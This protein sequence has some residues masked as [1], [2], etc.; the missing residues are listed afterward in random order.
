MA[1]RGTTGAP[2]YG[3]KLPSGANT[4]FHFSQ[5]N[6]GYY[7]ITNILGPSDSCVVLFDGVAI[8]GEW[9]WNQN[10]STDGIHFYITVAGGIAN[11]GNHTLSFSYDWTSAG[12]NHYFWEWMGAIG[13]M[14]YNDSWDGTLHLLIPPIVSHSFPW[15][16]RFQMCK[17]PYIA[18][19]NWFILNEDGTYVLLES[20]DKIEGE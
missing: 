4:K 15:I 10:F 1:E 20:N 14:T 19:P 8:S 5:K 13:P 17:V 6:T 18:P 9:Y 2:V 7:G 3:S 11:T 12:G 16:G